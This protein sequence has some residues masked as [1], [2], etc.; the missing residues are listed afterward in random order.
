MARDFM[1]KSSALMPYI[2]VNRDAA[3]AG[4][5]TVDGEA[6]SVDLT[7]KY[8]Q[9]TDYNQRVGS[10]EARITTVEGDVRDIKTAI[11]SIN[12]SITSI[13]SSLGNKAAKG[14]NSDITSL[15]A[16]SGPLRLGGDAVNAYDA[17]TLRQLQASSGS[18]GG[19][20][21]NG[22]MNNFIGA[23]TWFNGS[24]GVGLMPAG[25]LPADGQ[26]LKRADHPDTWAAISAGVL[27]SVSDA[28]WLDSGVSNNPAANRGMYSTGDGSTTFRMPDLNGSQSGS[29]PNLYLRGTSSD[30]SSSIPAGTTSDSAAPNIT[31]SYI[32][33]GSTG[34][35]SVRDATVTGAFTRSGSTK[36]AG[37]SYNT[38]NQSND[39]SI[40]ASKSSAVYGRDGV[41]E[42]RPRS[43][44]GIWIIRVNGSFV[45]ANTSFDVTTS[46]SSV[47]SSGVITYGGSVNSTY[48]VAGADYSKVSFRSKTVVGSNTTAAVGLVDTRTSTP[49]NKEWTFPQDQGELAVIVESGTTASGSY[50][51]YSDGTMIAQLYT[52]VQNITSTTRPEGNA[53]IEFMEQIWTFPVPFIS[54]PSVSGSASVW[55]DKNGSGTVRVGTWVSAFNQAIWNNQTSVR[56]VA[57]A[58]FQ[59]VVYFSRI[60]IGRWK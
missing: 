52:H 58:P 39:L 57:L 23:V 4:V 8:V 25:H 32:L 41:G 3:V 44:W 46:D 6:G 21:L 1:P 56:V 36:V 42:I 17:I 34:A 22:V 24:R 15:T 53:T 55:S 29:T 47:P 7:D 49:V 45:A 33:G 14:V 16:L 30:L 31:G 43:A 54:P 50:V 60:A 2:V 5:F 28:L 12:S 18:S 48:K 51:K 59:S 38:S 13:N 20:S 19:A 37:L 27:N 40:D 10:V 35:A 11:S 9:I 26:L